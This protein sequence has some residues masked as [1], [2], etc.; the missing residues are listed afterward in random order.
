[1]PSVVVVHNRLL[2]L[3]EEMAEGAAVEEE[4]VESTP[5]METG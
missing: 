3:M 4:D 2:K 1:M 5:I